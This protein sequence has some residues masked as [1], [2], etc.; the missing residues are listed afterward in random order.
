MDTL[1]DNKHKSRHCFAIRDKTETPFHLFYT[2]TIISG[3]TRKSIELNTRPACLST[4]SDAEIL[5]SRDADFHCNT[6]ADF[7]QDL[8]ADLNADSDAGLCAVQMQIFVCVRC[9]FTGRSGAMR[10][11]TCTYVRAG[12]GDK[13]RPLWRGLRTVRRKGV[14][15]QWLT[16]QP[17]K[18]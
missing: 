9:R 15:P 14:T 2:W 8:N 4:D 10:I 3:C 17:T 18:R 7:C 13:K 12:P 5:P 1:S 16:N 6:N 11:P